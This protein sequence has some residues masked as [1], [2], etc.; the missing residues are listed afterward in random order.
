MHSVSPQHG[1]ETSAAGESASV[2]PA[3]PTEQPE[4]METQGELTP[5]PTPTGEA[6]EV[7]VETTSAQEEE[8]RVDTTGD[9]RGQPETGEAPTTGELGPLP[10]RLGVI[11][12]SGLRDVVENLDFSA[13]NPQV[14]LAA[15]RDAVGAQVAQALREPLN[16]TVPRGKSPTPPPSSPEEQEKETEPEE[17][18]DETETRDEPPEKE[19]SESGGGESELGSEFSSEAPR[20]EVLRHQFRPKRTLTGQVGYSD[21]ASPTKFS[22]VTEYSHRVFDSVDVPLSR[23]LIGQGLQ[24]GQ[25][26]NL[27]D[28]TG[29]GRSDLVPLFYGGEKTVR[30]NWGQPHDSYLMTP[31]YPSSED[32]SEDEEH[33][34]Y[35]PEGAYRGREDAWKPPDRVTI[36]R[37]IDNESHEEGEE[38]TARAFKAEPRSGSG[39]AVMQ[40]LPILEKNA[41]LRKNVCFRDR[42]AIIEEFDMKAD[43]LVELY[44]L[45]LRTIERPGFYQEYR[46]IGAYHDLIKTTHTV[47]CHL[48]LRNLSSMDHVLFHDMPFDYARSKRVQEWRWRWSARGSSMKQFIG[49]IT[50]VRR[51]HFRE[52]VAKA[53]VDGPSVG[54]IRVKFRRRLEPQEGWTADNVIVEEYDKE[55]ADVFARAPHT[56]VDGVPV[57]KPAR[58]GTGLKPGRKPSRGCGGPPAGTGRV[59][60]PPVPTPQ[61]PPLLTPKPRKPRKPKTVQKGPLRKLT[62]PTARYSPERRKTSFRIPEQPARTGLRAVAAQPSEGP[63]EPQSTRITATWHREMIRAQRTT[64]LLIRR[65]PFQRLVREISREESK[66]LDINKHRTDDTEKLHELRWQSTALEAL[67]QAAEAYLVRL[68]EDSNLC[69][70]HGKR[71]TLMPKDM[72]LAR[73]IRN[74]VDHLRD[75][76]D[77]GRRYRDAPVPNPVFGGITGAASQSVHRDDLR[78]AQPRTGAR[79]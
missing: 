13:L 30:S 15:A 28:G 70:I 63:A 65:L 34:K 26:L 9:V 20:V 38:I 47:I 21:T 8:E 41:G 22:D 32:D 74:E 79:D 31:E 36:V 29:I 50:N 24:D 45:C 5:A 59:T 56:K 17:P 18:G 62:F 46:D 55:A 49:N 71:V 25:W 7:E 57:F 4:P 68:F 3:P 52:W 73:K 42:H 66:R 35:G 6:M 39:E 16:L 77:P 44:G 12:T 60:K 1:E 10:P 27:Q 78:V 54:T 11:S 76:V 64:G 51:R 43:L 48:M 69:A 53:E 19:P 14:D 23:M 67:H 40:F 61:R 72:T 75:T 58:K 37:P 33:E 2:T